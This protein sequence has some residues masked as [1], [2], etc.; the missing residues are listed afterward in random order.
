MT[1]PEI[2]DSI[3]RNDWLFS[4]VT[5]NNINYLYTQSLAK[6]E[7]DHSYLVVCENVNN[8][9]DA[10]P[11]QS[12]I[13][14]DILY[15]KSAKDHTT[16]LISDVQYNLYYGK[17]YIKY[18]HATPYVDYLNGLTYSK[19]IQDTQSQIDYY[20][21]SNNSE[22][23][24]MYS[25]TPSSINLYQ[26]NLDKSSNEKYKLTFFN[27]GT[28][29]VNNLSTKSGSKL[30][31]NFSGP[32]MRVKGVVGPEHGI[33]K[34]RIIKKANN[35]EETEE[36]IFDWVDVDCFNTILKE[37]TLIDIYNLEYFDYYIEIETTAE[38]NVLSSNKNIYIKEIQFLRNF[39]IQLGEENIN[40][41]LSFISIGGI[42]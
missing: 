16:G 39:N 17:D 6:E 21:V 24:A 40:P 20:K 15:F 41:D 7:Q 29:W 37:D 12:K 30:L 42:R 34:Y 25:S 27:D 2:K 8:S 32:K 35:T 36:V 28:D 13:V 10:T 3:H 23:Y 11:V 9:N 31:A 5:N 1:I 33:F 38:K 4:K 18:I 19:Y 26:Y 22:N 14:N